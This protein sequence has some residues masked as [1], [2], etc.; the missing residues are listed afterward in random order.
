MV[1]KDDEVWRRTQVLTRKSVKLFGPWQDAFPRCLVCGMGVKMRGMEE[2]LQ[3]FESALGLA[4]EIFLQENTLLKAGKLEAHTALMGEKK[5]LLEK[6][7]GSLKELEAMRENKTPAQKQKLHALQDS[8]MQL[9]MLDRENEQL[10]LK[11]SMGNFRSSATPSV[12]VD[13]LQKLYKKL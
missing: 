2:T 12:S 9:L 8:V 1:P 7:D 4:R 11:L 13:S 6:L 3:N 5:K 10:L